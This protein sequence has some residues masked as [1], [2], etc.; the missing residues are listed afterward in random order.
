V[1]LGSPAEVSQAN[2]QLDEPLA[3]QQSAGTVA[4][5]GERE[6]IFEPGQH[7]G[8]TLREAAFRT[9]DVARC[10]AVAARD[11]LLRT[12]PHP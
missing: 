4:L 2:Q 12:P 3:V 9:L 11:G 1:V 5:D 10:M 8:V 6:L 7:V